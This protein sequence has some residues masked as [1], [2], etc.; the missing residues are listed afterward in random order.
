M[1]KIISAFLLL[2]VSCAYVQAE[3][4]EE[5]GL[6]I[7]YEV[8]ARDN[9]FVDT[10]VEL[11]MVLRDVSGNQNARSMRL[12]ILEVPEDGDKSL[13]VF[14]SPPD[15]R[16]TGLLTFSH[17][18]ASD[19]QWLNL[20][21]LK[22]VKRIASKN[23]SGPFVGSE[24]AFEDLAS[25]EVEKYTYRFVREEDF[26]GQA[27]FVIERVPVDRYSGYTRQVAWV[28]KAEYRYQKIDYYDRKGSLLKT[29]TSTGYQKYNGAFW[30]ADSMYMINHQTGKSTE[31]LWRNYEF[32]TGLKDSDFTK[33][34]L[35]RMR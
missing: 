1:I 21:A 13:T 23:K 30:R 35:Q 17:K 31:L 6:A 24:F 18:V 34:S 5:K 32:D 15:I 11:E 20:P 8:D 12:R 4:A 25:Q 7:A 26:D 10:K 19:D 27:C 29:L 2:S 22:R 16:G 3:S 9:G 33:N 14:D 28:D